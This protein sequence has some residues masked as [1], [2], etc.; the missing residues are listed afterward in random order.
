MIRPERI[1]RNNSLS[2]RRRAPAS[3][4]LR[5]HPFDGRLDLIVGQRR[6]AALGRH[7]FAVLALVAVDGVTDQRLQAFGDARCPR[8]LVRDDR[9]AGSGVGVTGLAKVAESRL[10]VCGAAIRDLRFRRLFR[11]LL[12]GQ[13]RGFAGVARVDC[14]YRSN[15][16]K[17]LFFMIRRYRRRMFGVQVHRQK[18]QREHDQHQKA[19]HHRE[20]AEKDA[21]AVGNGV[22]HGS[23]SNGHKAGREVYRPGRGRGSRGYAMPPFTPMIWPLTYDAA[24]E[25]RKPTTAATS[26]GDPARAAGTICLMW[27]ASNDASAICP[28]ITPGATT[29]T[30]MPRDAISRASDFAAP[31]RADFAAA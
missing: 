2:K 19:D 6:I 23:P 30:V 15:T 3:L 24:S 10:A 20:M 22:G 14:T 17:D 7:Q 12:S 26:S 16:L 4:N 11:R 18:D 21:V 31:C 5:N 29:L 27:S 1:R 9:R 8:G 25:Q 13:Q 28:A